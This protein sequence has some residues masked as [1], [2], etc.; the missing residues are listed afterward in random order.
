MQT[1]IY[2]NLTEFEALSHEWD[3]FLART[4]APIFMQLAY[5]RVWWQY[6]GQGELLL[7][8]IRDENSQLVGAAPLFKTSN[9][10]GQIQLALVGCMAVSDYLDVL[11]DP[12]YIAPVYQALLDYLS[13][14][15]T[16]DKLYLCSLPHHSPTHTRLA[17]TM[18]ARGWQ[19]TRTQQ[20]VCPVLTL[21][22]SWDN[23]LAGIDKK[24]RHEI[25]RKIGK[26][27]RAAPIRWYVIDSVAD[28]HEAMTAF[29]T[30]HQLSAQDKEEFWNE[31]LIQF[32]KALAQEMAQAGWLKL[33]FLDIDGIKAA[34][35][36]CFDY[37]NQFFLYN[38]GY[39]PKYFNL[40]PGNVLTAYTIQEAIRLG[41]S[42]YDFMRG[43]EIYKFR[44]GAQAEPLYDLEILR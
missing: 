19:V 28:L 6:L 23:Y 7:I 37:A 18:Q 34:A 41:R 44:F 16:W 36:L 40:S 24:Q 38:S 17:E 25:R 8:T 3:N 29:I 43:D 31:S 1:I 11:V 4:A 42:R 26:L 35:M 27:E 13:E 30:L 9:P 12:N 20:D 21:A 2:T 39:D 10:A 33:Y 22:D 32:F 5:Q 15:V 14:S